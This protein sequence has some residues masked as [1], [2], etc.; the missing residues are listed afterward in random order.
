MQRNIPSHTI[1]GSAP[2]QKMPKHMQIQ[3]Q[4]NR[5][6]KLSGADEFKDMIKR[7]SAYYKNNNNSISGLDIPNLLCVIRKG[8]GFT[9]LAEHFAEYL[10]LLDSMEFCG[11]AKFVEFGPEYVHPDNV[12]TE[13]PLLNG[14]I[15]AHAG[16]N[17]YYKGLVCINM[18][19]W[20]H[21]AGEAHIR[22]ILDYLA[23]NRNKW[24]TV[25][26]THIDKE[27]T[28]KEFETAIAQ[29][30]NVETL[31]ISFPETSV[32]TKNIEISLLENNGITLTKGAKALMSYTIEE[33][34]GTEGF[35]GF[36]SVKQLEDSVV[37]NFLIKNPDGKRISEAALK[38]IL[39]NSDYIGKRKKQ[40]TNQTPIG[41]IR[42]GR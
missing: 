22:I 11:T 42:G 27:D 8:G 14:T 38:E 35:L 32:L 21:H 4:Y 34:S 25:F 41:F 9:T 33:L 37:F 17:R 6:M 16:Y 39:N 10:Y 26:F 40:P 3:Q 1:V 12:N 31:K 36:Q 28:I 5:I 18:D 2:P 19:E 7:F 30:M 23:D 29:R 24:L 15:T 20:Q 13:L